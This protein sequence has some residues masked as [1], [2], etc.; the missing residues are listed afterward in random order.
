MAFRFRVRS[1]LS[2]VAAAAAAVVA[3]C[4]EPPPPEAP[5]V[6]ASLNV[7]QRLID[8]ASGYRA[9]VNRARTM[10]PAFV[11]GA[12]V[13]AALSAGAAY[14]PQQ[15]VRGAIAYGAVVA[16]QDRTFTA[17]VRAHA[18]DPAQRQEMAYAILRD[19]YYVTS[20]PGA[21]SA[22]SAVSAALTADG[23][24]IYDQGGRIKQAAYDIQAQAWSKNDV[25]DRPLRLQR[26]KAPPPLAGDLAEGERLRTAISSAAPVSLGPAVTVPAPTAYPSIAVR[27]LGVAAIAAL[28]YSGETQ[29]DLMTPLMVDAVGGDC[30]NLA[31]LDLYQC[32]AVSKPHYEDVFCLGRHAM[33]D[34]GLCLMK[35]TGAPLPAIEVRPIATGV[36]PTAQPYKAAPKAKAKAKAKAPARPKA[37]SR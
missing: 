34:T 26:V 3:G 24:A 16:L 7:S 31:K 18:A 23:Q 5:K 15:F 21:A 17:G 9:Y 22:A 27:A 8:M 32:L 10:S 28:G 1:A 36:S 30:L 14:D 11:D 20:F 29:P 6:P 35:S 19:P 33:M 37:K 25:I 2:F 4:A 12:A 13:A